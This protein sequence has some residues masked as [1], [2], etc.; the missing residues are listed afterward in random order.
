MKSKLA[1]LVMGLFVLA[2]SM[3]ILNTPNVDKKIR[4]KKRKDDTENLFV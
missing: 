2:L 1:K 4:T 3:F